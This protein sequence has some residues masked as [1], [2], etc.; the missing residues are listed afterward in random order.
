MPE[1][2]ATVFIRHPEATSHILTAGLQPF[3]YL[4]DAKLLVFIR[5][6]LNLARETKLAGTA[7]DHRLILLHQ[8]R[9]S[10]YPPLDWKP[11][12]DWLVPESEP[13]LDSDVWPDTVSGIKTRSGLSVLAKRYVHCT[14]RHFVL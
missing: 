6:H 3:R 5:D 13:G 2:N 1:L 7:R 4:A 8:P 12:G 9:M 10:L 11:T 14:F